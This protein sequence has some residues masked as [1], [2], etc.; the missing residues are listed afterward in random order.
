MNRTHLY[1]FMVRGIAVTAMPLL[2]A[3]IAVA[4]KNIFRFFP[5]QGCNLNF[6]IYICSG[7]R[8]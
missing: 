1:T 5:S 6:I 2:Q 7:I 3:E 8:L 4:E